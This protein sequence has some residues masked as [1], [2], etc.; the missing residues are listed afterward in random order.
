MTREKR[1][2]PGERPRLP[3]L[4]EFIVDHTQKLRGFP[5]NGYVRERGIRQLY[6]RIGPRYINGERLPCVLDLAN[7][8]VAARQRG[9]G[10]FTRLI[11]RLRRDYPDLP[12]YAESVL[13][14]RLPRKLKE[15]GFEE[16]GASVDP[17]CYIL[18]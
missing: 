14:P 7:I 4:D 1:T 12:L 16:V 3:T 2:Q 8:E 11:Q 17:P 13:Q 15:L 10:R 9:Q 18:R 6:V 5:R